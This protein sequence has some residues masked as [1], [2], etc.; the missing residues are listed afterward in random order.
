MS[1][2]PI[3]RLYDF[4]LIDL[5]LNIL[6]GDKKPPELEI[7]F[8][9][10][11]VGEALSIKLQTDNLEESLETNKLILEHLAQS[12]SHSIT[13]VTIA[14]RE[15]KYFISY[16]RAEE[17]LLDYLEITAPS[18]YG[19]QGYSAL[20]A[21]AVSKIHA[22]LLSI[23]AHQPHFITD[24]PASL[25]VRGEVLA[26]LQKLS[27]DITKDQLE[28]R[29]T[30]DLEKEKFLATERQRTEARLAELSHDYQLQSEQLEEKY[31][32]QDEKL[33]AREQA[34]N[35]ADNTTT[36]RTTTANVLVD[37][38]EKAESFEF[39]NSVAKGR[40][41]ILVL[42]TIIAAFGLGNIML[43][44]YYFSSIPFFTKGVS[45]LSAQTAQNDYLTWLAIAK[46]FGGS[47]LFIS[48]IVYLI[49]HQSQ[50]T[51][52]A[53]NVELDYQKFS[54]DL[55]RAHVTIEMC[56]EWNDKKE[57]QI[58][59]TLLNAMT[60][61]LFTEN[62]SK[63]EEILHPAEQL[64]AAMIKSAERIEFPLGSSKIVTRGK[65]IPKSSPPST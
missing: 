46:I 15:Q 43:G 2:S 36:R 19:I 52:K 33:V 32:L 5:F 54:R 24:D 18:N 34:V 20:D 56:L 17:G 12:Q 65:N 58:P 49:R 57:G 59:E 35:D 14:P 27:S 55:N 63:S 4:Q 9:L 6:T 29:K 28:Y 1:K 10:I 64:A 41:I 22:S 37:V 26:Q 61:G 40:A 23:A 53:A 16:T 39:S 51:N 47:F 31:R 21:I 7:A 48:S 60:N 30:L 3:P 38:K 8:L 13:K 50:W 62:Q 45:E 25:S 42:S 44:T 11:K